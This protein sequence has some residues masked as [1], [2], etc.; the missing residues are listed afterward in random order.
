MKERREDVDGVPLDIVDMHQSNGCD[1]YKKNQ[2]INIK[3][4]LTVLTVKIYLANRV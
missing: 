2:M 4:R 3:E 1:F